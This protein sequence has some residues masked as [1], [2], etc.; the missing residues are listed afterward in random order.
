MLINMGREVNVFLCIY[1]LI[2]LVCGR[3]VNLCEC[4]LSNNL[5]LEKMTFS[6]I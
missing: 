6:S 3:S 2:H 4:E 1:L 5:V